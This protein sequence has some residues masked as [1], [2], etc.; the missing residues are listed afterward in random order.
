MMSRRFQ[1]FRSM[2]QL[3]KFENFIFITGG[4]LMVAGVGCCVF[5]IFTNIMSLVFL[6][7]TLMFASM[8]ALQ[9]YEGKSVVIRRL[10]RIMLIADVLFVVAGLLMVERAWQWLFP[11]MA[12]TLDG[13]ETYMRYIHNN[14]VVVLLVAAILEMYTMHRISNELA[15]ED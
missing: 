6:A 3:N 2:R 14:W 10:R 1:P 12:T 13:Y 7:G 15:K 4:I 5:D 8:Q 11:H 9:R